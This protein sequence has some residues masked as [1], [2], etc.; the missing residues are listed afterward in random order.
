MTTKDLETRASTSSTNVLDWTPYAA[1][2]WSVLF[3]AISFYWASGGDAGVGALAQS[4][5]ELAR[6]RDALFVAEVW[7][8]GALKLLA[9]VMAL[10][11]V[12]P[13]GGIV[14]GRLLRI[15]VWAIGAILVLYGGSNLIQNVLIEAG[16]MGVPA[17]MGAQAV[18][19]YLFLW[20][21]YWVLG[22]LLF[23]GAAWS[24]RNR[25]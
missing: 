5:Q 18:R 14:P 24:T 11:L 8:T 15:A 13:W 22:G 21:P 7:A 20:E 16:V 19:W 9:G 23:L 10:A 25:G 12:R 6:K 4:I 17:S 3:A 1:C 2:A